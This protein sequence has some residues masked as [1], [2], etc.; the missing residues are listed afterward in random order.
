ML[1][2]DVGVMGLVD[3]SQQYISIKAFSGMRSQSWN[4]LKVSLR[5]E[6][7][8]ALILDKPIIAEDASL[9]GGGELVRL[10]KREGIL[11][12]IAV[13]LWRGGGLRGLVG[14][15]TRQRRRFSIED[16]QLLTR[17]AQQTIVS[18]ENAQLYQQ[19]H[20]VS[21]LEE[22]ERIAREIHDGLAQLVGSMRVWSEEAGLSLEERNWKA[23]RS[24]IKKVEET[25][26][27]AYANLREEMMGL[28]ETIVPRQGIFPLLAEYL[29]RFQSEW[30]IQ[31]RLEIRRPVD[32]IDPIAFSPNAEIQLLRIVQ[33]GLTNVHRH[34]KAQ[35]VLVDCIETAEAL[36]I[37]IQDDGEGFDPA[38]VPD[39][40]LGLHIMSERAASVG[41]QVS[42]SSQ[43][44][45]GTRLEIE[46]PR[47][48][49][50]RSK[51]SVA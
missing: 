20:Y 33:E 27:V 15:M 4:E 36:R 41:G 30:G 3:P 40:H 42:V 45:Q 5:T 34:A 13:P 14:V 37:S 6:P 31:S 25:A 21:V 22:R 17:L 26:R 47:E 1:S 38:N 23:S 11:S 7:G 8:S 29:A 16:V 28:R 18:I 46:F 32:G 9:Q 51:G 12:L 10:L 49:V 35:H 44:G 24:A 50:G 39:G 2:A 43:F 19:A 48:Q